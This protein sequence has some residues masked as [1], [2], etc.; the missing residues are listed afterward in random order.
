MK[1]V[2]LNSNTFVNPN[3]VRQVWETTD[4]VYVDIGPGNE[5]LIQ[6]RKHQGKILYNDLKAVVSALEA[7][8]NHN[9]E[10]TE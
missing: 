5:Q 2:Q 4:C 3:A 1:F 9:P 10:S 8:L 7:G 6:I